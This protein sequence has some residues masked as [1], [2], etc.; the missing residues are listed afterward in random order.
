MTAGF[1]H[2]TRLLFVE[3]NIFLLLYG[4]TK[5][6]IAKAL[7]EFTA[8]DRFFHDLFAV[9]KLYLGIQPALGLDAYQRAHFAK[10]VAAAFFHADDF[11][12]RFLCKFHLDRNASCFQQLFEPGIDVQRPACHTA[13][14]SANQN[15]FCFG[16]K[17]AFT[18]FAQFNE[19]VS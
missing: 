3:R 7:N 6:M 5:L 16:S 18:G 1:E 12:V 11:A 19:V 10:A 13:C 15:L 17:R 2:N 8:E 9:L 4:F 14:A